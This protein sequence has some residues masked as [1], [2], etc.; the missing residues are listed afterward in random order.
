MHHGCMNDLPKQEKYL[1]CVLK[2]LQGTKPDCIERGA[3]EKQSLCI[4]AEVSAGS[5]A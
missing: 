4:G 5:E 1:T 3:C 2:P